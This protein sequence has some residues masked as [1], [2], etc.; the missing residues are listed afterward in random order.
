MR[1]SLIRAIFIGTFFFALVTPQTARAQSP[2]PSVVSIMLL[3]TERSLTLYIA[4]EGRHDLRGLA[5]L[6][7]NSQ[8]Q[9]TLRRTLDEDYTSFRG[10]PFN[11][12]PLPTCFLLE[13]SGERQPFPEEC[14]NGVQSNNRHRQ[15]VQPGNVFWYT[16][17]DGTLPVYVVLG[18]SETLCP[19]AQA[20]CP[21]VLSG[22]L[23]TPTAA[24]TLSVTAAP[25][26][27]V[28]PTATATP[29]GAA[30][31][32]GFPRLPCQAT[33][34]GGNSALQPL[35]VYRLPDFASGAVRT[36][37]RNSTIFILEPPVVN[38]PSAA[39]RYIGD[40]DKQPLGWMPLNSI[41]LGTDCP[42]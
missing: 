7:R 22:Q 17:D 40:K 1:T 8:G 35:T 18:S 23:A 32:T 31:V 24:P 2:T 15:A 12:L 9:E 28:T 20:R 21:I 4:G 14:Q 26:T 34:V 16:D 30:T 42:R 39:W 13:R 10:L 38:I 6:L 37:A 3:R 5:F 27:P 11:A 33:T 36:I 19:A 29:S 41:I 25:A